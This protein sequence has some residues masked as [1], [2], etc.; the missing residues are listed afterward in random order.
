MA[1]TPRIAVPRSVASGEVFEIKTLIAH[2][3]ETGRRPGPDGALVPR[4]LIHRFVCS[5][6]GATLFELELHPGIAANPYIQF[7]AR[8]ERSGELV[9]R[10]FDDDGSVYEATQ[11]IE[12][13]G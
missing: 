6:E 3:M 11:R 12:V 10:W 9:F 2:V 8:L 4:H 13:T 7:H 1:P 5:F